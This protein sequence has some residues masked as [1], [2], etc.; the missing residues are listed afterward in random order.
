MWSQSLSDLLALK[1]TVYS[2]ATLRQTICAVQSGFG[3]VHLRDDITRGHRRTFVIMWYLLDTIRV[4][5]LGLDPSTPLLLQEELG[6]DTVL[7]RNLFLQVNFL[8][9][10]EAWNAIHISLVL[11]RRYDLFRLLEQLLYSQDQDFTEMINKIVEEIELAGQT[12]LQGL[13]HLMYE[14]KVC[15]LIDI[16]SSNVIDLE[17]I[18]W[19][20]GAVDISRCIDSTCYCDRVHPNR[21]Q[22]RSSNRSGSQRRRRSSRDK[23]RSPSTRDASRS[24]SPK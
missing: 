11:V 18:E 14:A 2:G 24:R 23:S 6:H 21:H 5:T 3:I 13:D 10:E 20:Q 9:P 16:S 22:P 8:S 15:R 7:G 1:V 19:W 4:A 12:S 17:L